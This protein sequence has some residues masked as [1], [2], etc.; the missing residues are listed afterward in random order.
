MIDLVL[1]LGLDIDLDNELDF[2]LGFDLEVGLDFD[3]VTDFCSEA[4]GAPKLELFLGG[5]MRRILNAILRA[6][7]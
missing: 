6:K 1:D 5:M 2:E 3:L 7:T 4:M